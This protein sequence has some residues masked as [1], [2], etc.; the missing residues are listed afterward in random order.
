MARAPRGGAGALALTAV[1][2]AGLLAGVM[3][4]DGSPSGPG[5]LP[6]HATTAGACIA[7]LTAW[8]RED[9][10]TPNRVRPDADDTGLV[11]SVAGVDGPPLTVGGE[12]NEPALAIGHG[13]GVT[14]SHFRPDTGDGIPAGEEIA[15]R[16][17]LEE[18]TGLVESGVRLSLT[19]C[20]GT[21]VRA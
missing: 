15:I 14:G 18:R 5:Y 6:G 17:L 16:T 10:V 21:R 7:V 3:T 20:D 4:P 12:L 11:P 19:R 9:V 2:A 13:R 8:F 1:G